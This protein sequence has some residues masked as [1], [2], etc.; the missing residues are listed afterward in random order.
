MVSK[1]ISDG[2]KKTPVENYLVIFLFAGHGMLKDGM[3][4][5]LYN[6]YDKKAEFYKLMMAEAKL[7]GWAEIYPNSYIIGI[8]ACC[9]QL[10]KNETMCDCISREEAEQYLKF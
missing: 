10:H 8:F 1:R 6:E 2:K 7:R 9:R 3:Q 4:V 5:M